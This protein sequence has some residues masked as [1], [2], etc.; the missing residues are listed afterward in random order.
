MAKTA[1]S[2]GLAQHGLKLQ[3]ALPPDICLHCLSGGAK[4]AV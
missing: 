4:R 3:V 2:F 1:I